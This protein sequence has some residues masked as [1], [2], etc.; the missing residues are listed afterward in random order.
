MDRIDGIY[1]KKT[2]GKWDFAMTVNGFLAGLVA[3]TLAM[4]TGSIS[5]ARSSSVSAP[6]S[7]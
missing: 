3:I 7:L 1:Y 6:D 4:L 2:D 5:R